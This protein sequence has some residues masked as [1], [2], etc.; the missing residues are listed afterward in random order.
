LIFLSDIAKKVS[1][2]IWLY[3]D[4]DKIFDS[5]EKSITDHLKIETFSFLAIVHITKVFSNIKALELV[6]NF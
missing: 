2:N 6:Q 5:N 3:L 4:N 1:F